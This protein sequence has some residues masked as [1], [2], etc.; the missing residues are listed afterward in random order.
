MDDESPKVA[1]YFVS[2]GLNNVN[3]PETDTET[4]EPITDL[5][6]IFKSLGEQCPEGYECVD[7][8][9]SGLPADLNHGSIRTQSCFLCYKRG[10]DKPPL[11]DIGVLFEGRQHLMQGC[12]IVHKTPAKHVANVN[13]GNNMRI[14]ITYRRAS[15]QFSHSS[16]AVIEISVIVASKGEKPPHAFCKIPKNLNQGLVG[17]EVYLCYR[18]SLLRSN[19][20]SYDAEIISRYPV[21]DQKVYPLPDSIPLFCLPLGAVIECW[22]EKAQYPLPIFSTFALTDAKGETI[23]GG[24]V[25]FF[26]EFDTAMMTKEVTQLIAQQQVVHPD[27]RVVP[28]TNR[29]ICLLSRFPFFEAFRKFLLSLYRL[30]VSGAQNIPIERYITHFMHQVPFPT[31]QKPIVCVQ[32]T[33]EMFEITQPNEG[34]LPVSGAS[35]TDFLRCLGPDKSLTLLCCILFEHKILVHSLRPALLT[36]VCEALTS[37]I[38]PFKWKCPYIPLCPL[39]LADV[40]TAPIPFIVGVDSR[41]FD[42]GH[43]DQIAD[44]T[45][46]DLDTCMITQGLDPNRLAGSEK[47]LPKKAAKCLKDKLNEIFPQL[48]SVK[49]EDLSSAVDMAPL[50]EAA[51]HSRKKGIETAIQEAFLRFHAQI[52]SGYKQFLLPIIS[53]PGVGA[54][55]ISS[56]FDLQTFM[57]SRPRGTERFYQ[58]LTKTQLFGHFIESRSLSSAND[59]FVFFDDCIDKCDTPARLLFGNNSSSTTTVVV[60]PPDQS[61]L[62]EGKTYTYNGFPKLD[63][64]LLTLKSPVLQNVKNRSTSTPPRSPSICRTPHE[65]HL[66]TLSAKKQAN[67]PT[68]WAACLLGHCYTI[69]FIHLPALLKHHKK[70]QKVN[71]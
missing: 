5:A 20:L 62:P 46:V 16:L 29:C 19:T 22:P 18:K 71:I 53:Q 12:D 33:H 13:N 2:V 48:Q 38:F 24:G 50:D 25:T 60:T 32:L 45:C 65:R 41:Y 70:K 23:Y 49:S 68:L 28:Q 40:L 69:W 39:K 64:E 36:S 55:D 7:V 17:S 66:G 37:L 26:E 44:V 56:L 4:L 59:V 67:S 58:A 47:V 51:S 6:I 1:D 31:P 21:E 10:R 43:P 9:Q 61:G 35:F 63:L 54:R 34:P 30:T 3:K 15:P 57:K 8:T 14:F 27:S 52:L 11:T 42:Q